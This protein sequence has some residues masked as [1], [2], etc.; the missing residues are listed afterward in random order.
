MWSNN[1]QIQIQI[2]I[3]YSTIIKCVFFLELSLDK[4]KLQTES[5]LPDYQ[6]NDISTWLESKPKGVIMYFLSSTWVGKDKALIN[7]NLLQNYI[8]IIII[9]YLFLF[10][11]SNHLPIG[12]DIKYVTCDS[13]LF[14][15]CHW[16]QIKYRY[17]LG[18]MG[19]TRV[20]KTIYTS[21]KY[22]III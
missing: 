2:Q 16:Y 19:T 10:H 1:L 8:I 15:I 22:N 20:V 7:M 13:S 4:K 11:R 6:L 14:I 9:Y 5:I 12:L 3:Q 21:Y 17:R 18:V